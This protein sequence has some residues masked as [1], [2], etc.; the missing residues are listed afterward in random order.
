MAQT[1]TWALVAVEVPQLRAMQEKGSA[2][3]ALYRNEL[4]D[5]SMH[6]HVVSLTW[7]GSQE[8]PRNL[9]GYPL[10]VAFGYVYVGWVTREDVMEA[11]KL[12]PEDVWV[13]SEA[14]DA[15]SAKERRTPLWQVRL[16][17][18]RREVK[19]RT[20]GGPTMPPIGASAPAG[21]E[22]G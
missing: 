4:L 13:W 5:S 1:E 12:V 20:S 9:A 11:V 3:H 22:Q 8:R 17:A 19:I 18:C 15:L 10:P 21:E 14:Y 6:G 7:D 16:A 2:A